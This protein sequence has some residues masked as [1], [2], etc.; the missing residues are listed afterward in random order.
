MPIETHR[1]A[2]V[3]NCRFGESLS[4]L[5]KKLVVAVK[6]SNSKSFCGCLERHLDALVYLI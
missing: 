3:I 1:R 6:P 4:H 2:L 5:L